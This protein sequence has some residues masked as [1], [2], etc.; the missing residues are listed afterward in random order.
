MI[1]P[2][3]QVFRKTAGVVC[4]LRLLLF[5]LGLAQ[6]T[7]AQINDNKIYKGPESPSSSLPVPH[8]PIVVGPRLRFPPDFLYESLHDPWFNRHPWGSPTSEG[9]SKP[10]R[11]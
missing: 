11:K 6:C 5:V 1:G 4:H 9:I 10:A 3:Q 8:N 2:G 7:F